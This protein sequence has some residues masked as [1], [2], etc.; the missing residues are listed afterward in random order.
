MI[1]A[2]G[3]GLLKLVV[4]AYLL[5]PAEYGGYVA[6]FG[7]ATLSAALM[8]FGLIE[9]TIKK[10]PRK[11]ADGERKSIISDS[12]GRG[13]VLVL[14][15][16]L[17]LGVLIP[18]ALIANHSTKIIEIVFFCTI[19]VGSALLS[20]VA[21]LFRATGSKKALQRFSLWRSGFAFGLATAFGTL[22]GFHGAL[23]GESIAALLS[24]SLSFVTL[25]KLYYNDQHDAGQSDQ[26]DE[27]ATGHRKL[28]IANTFT[29]STTMADR[30][31]VAFALGPVSAG[32]Y[33]VIMILPQIS[34]MLVNVVSQYIGPYVIKLVH[35]GDMDTSKSSS[36]I[37]QT[38]LLA[39]LVSVI[40]FTLFALSELESVSSFFEKYSL[41]GAFLV[42]ACILSVAQIAALIEFHLIARDA[43]HLVFKCSIMA[44]SMF[45][46]T[47]AI[48]SQRQLDVEYFIA[49]A[50]TA[51]LVHA[52]LLSKSLVKINK[53]NAV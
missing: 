23:V 36:L 11:W 28:Y 1:A 40:G 38:C 43:E 16:V 3:F 35:K 13:K 39:A 10:Y 25:R 46:F 24:I 49:S 6:L 5:D 30:S 50:A 34:Q 45:F 8:S 18:I 15:F 51:K 20:L 41:T 53:S 42:L 12:K 4:L 37:Y 9:E 47:F 44:N 32:T 48:C 33:G 26:S 52:A 22:W 31:I 19:G 21:S 2:S 7:A 29:A 14:R 27:R 17:L